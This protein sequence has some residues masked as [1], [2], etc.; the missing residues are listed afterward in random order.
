MHFAKKRISHS[1]SSVTC[2]LKFIPGIIETS[3]CASSLSHYFLAVYSENYKI[4]IC[5]AE[6]ILAVELRV[7]VNKMNIIMRSG[8]T[9]IPRYN[10]GVY[11]CVLFT[12]LFMLRILCRRAG[13]KATYFMYIRRSTDGAEKC[14]KRSLVRSYLPAEYI[15]FC[16]VPLL[17]VYIAMPIQNRSVRYVNRNK[18]VSAI[19]S[20]A[21]TWRT[22]QFH[23]K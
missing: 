17:E 9:F 7:Q 13:A 20:N 22:L 4:Q 11:A 16:R 3:N 18:P 15:Y 10:I 6:Y 1:S 21:F 5:A 19:L 14:F 8:R 23:K 12:H 2:Y